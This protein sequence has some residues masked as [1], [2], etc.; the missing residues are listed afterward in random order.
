MDCSSVNDAKIKLISG[1]HYQ[2]SDGDVIEA[3][4]LNKDG[5]E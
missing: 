3:V 2:L 4:T 5:G 1:K